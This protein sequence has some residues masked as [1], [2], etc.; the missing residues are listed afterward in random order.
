EAARLA[1]AA[2]A[3]LVPDTESSAAA[4][5]RL[6]APGHAAAA[7]RHID[8]ERAMARTPTAPPGSAEGYA[9]ASAARAAETTY[10]AV[11]DR[12]RNAASVMATIVDFWG[13]RL[14]APESGVLL[15][16]RGEYFT[17][18]A[19]DPNCWAP[20]KRPLSYSLPSMVVKDGRVSHVLGVVGG[21][22]QPTGVLHVLT[23]MI[24]F[25]LDPQAALT[26]P[27]AFHADG[28]VDVE[29]GVADRVAMDLAARGHRVV[30]RAEGPRRQS[31]PLG[32]GQVVAI[33]WDEG[34]LVGAADP[35]KDG[36]AIG[37]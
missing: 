11:V 20:G 3:E 9:E 36:S 28:V 15:N 24:D 18:D 33:D 10:L 35:R 5:T 17:T 2:R 23:N 34:L 32:G 25:G 30:R 7:R 6:L 31:G 22:Y 1:Y 16:S 19:S 37:Y 26:V 14:T 27:R 21:S 12:D 8:R 13:S 29:R 4:V